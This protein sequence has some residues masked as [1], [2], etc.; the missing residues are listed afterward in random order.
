MYNV[1]LFRQTEGRAKNDVVIT[2]RTQM[3]L[4][5][6]VFNTL[7]SLDYAMYKQLNSLDIK[8]RVKQGQ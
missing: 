6:V 4:I 7:H 1:N 5:E 3:L 2:S 8:F